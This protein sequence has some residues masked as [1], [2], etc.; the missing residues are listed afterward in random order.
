[1][2][3]LSA[4]Q[5]KIVDALTIERQ[6]ISSI[7]LM[8]RVAK[9]CAERICSQ[10]TADLPVVVF[11]GMGNN[12]G[13]GL[14][15]ARLLS[16]QNRMVQVIVVR[17]TEHFSADAQVNFDRLPESLQATLI[18][19]RS[20]NDAGQ[21]HIKENTCVIDAMLGT[22]INKP[23]TGILETVIHKIN[24]APC[25]VISIDVPSGLMIDHS[26]GELPDACV[27]ADLVLSL[28]L[29]K[30]AYLFPENKRIVPHFE[31]VDIGLDQQA[32]LEQPSPYYFA[33]RQDIA[34]LL[35]PRNKFSHKGTYGHALLLAGSSGTSGAAVIAAEACLRSGA[36]LLTVHST[37]Q[38]VDA[39]S[40]RLPEAMTQT[41]EHD[42]FITFC[43]DLS[44]YRAI[45]FGPGVGRASE[46]QQLLKSVIQR[47]QGRLI[48]DADGL[49]I[50][51]ENKTW[52]EFLP[53]DT[54]LTPHPKE[55]ERL[56]GPSDTHFDRLQK[57][58]A[59]AT[60]YT[61][62]LILKDTY[63]H[64]CMPDGSVVFNSTGNAGLAKGGSGD[65]LTGIILGLLTR[66]YPP[67]QAALTGTFIHGYTADL[68]AEMM[69]QESILITDVI[70]QLPCAFKQLES[71]NKFF[72]S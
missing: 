36:G 58:R 17:H 41:D 47:F 19:V 37:K 34:A 48:I 18:T 54:I 24:S 55:F 7:D 15:I 40:Y 22:G 60:R 68:C 3:I 6:H 56:A 70:R 59:F 65:C 63:T 4:T 32:L 1:M 42:S 72:R 53:K 11:C 35:V 28:Q 57:A 8:E 51:A 39:L 64:I 21:L 31:C 52:L 16:E 2:K 26:S 29:P 50:L 13:D 69:S 5:L 66:G 44:S 38:T 9:I 62:I 27:Q 20:E 49:N 10:Y 43:D 14:A 30:L 45:G 67:P 46:T 33:E 23:V 61:C 71:T 25:T 12:G